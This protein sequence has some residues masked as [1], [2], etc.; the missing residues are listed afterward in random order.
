MGISKFSPDGSMLLYR[1]FIGGSNNET[2]NSLIAD[3]QDNVIIYGV[4]YSTDFR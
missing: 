4:S 3:A 2:P 1:T